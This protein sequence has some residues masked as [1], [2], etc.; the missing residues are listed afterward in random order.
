[1]PIDRCTSDQSRLTRA[2]LSLVFLAGAG[3]LLVGAHV[4]LM[5]RRRKVVL[6][7]ATLAPLKEALGPRQSLRR[8]V[9]PLLLLLGL[10]VA[11]L[12]VARPTATVTLPSD[13]RTIVM[14]EPIK[15]LGV[16]T[17]TARLAKDVTVVGVADRVEIWDVEAWEANSSE[18]DDLYAGIEEALS[19]EGI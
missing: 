19:G 2:S 6:R 1:M 13:K 15:T 14:P 17:V 8:H 10:M 18:A 12:A 16:F 3:P 9:P 11:L 4:L 7:Y 5:R